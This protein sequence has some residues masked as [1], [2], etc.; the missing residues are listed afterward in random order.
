[1]CIFGKLLGCFEKKIKTQKIADNIYL[2]GGVSD[3][4]KTGMLVVADYRGSTTSLELKVEGMDGA[5]IK[6]EYLDQENML[7]L[8][9]ATFRNNVLT[10]PKK[11]IGS[12]AFVIYFDKN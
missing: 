8:I 3:D 5:N 6:V 2:Q 4:G 12:A 1:M 10:L 7:T 11:N 9:D